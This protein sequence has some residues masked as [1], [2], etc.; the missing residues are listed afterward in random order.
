MYNGHVPINTTTS[1]R[2][3]AVKPGFKPTN[4]DTHTYIFLDDVI[5]QPAR[6]NGFPANWGHTGRGDYEMDPEVVNNARYRNTIK[7]DLLSVPT[8][9]LVMDVDDWFE[10]GG[11]GI[12][13]QGER[14]ERAVSAE[15][16]FPD[17]RQGFQINCSVMIVGGSS[18][19]RWKMDKLSMR[20]KFK[21]EYG[22]SKLRFPVFGGDVTDEFDTLVVDARMNNSWGYGGGVMLPNNSRP[23]ISGRPSQ[24][25][26]AQY[27]RD[28]FVA[29]IQN[30][31]GGYA[32]HGRHIHLYLNGLYWGLYWLHE[33]PDEHFAAVYFGGDDED[34]DVLKHRSSSVIS[35]T[36]ASYNRLFNIA[37]AGLASASQY[38]LIQQYLDVPNLIDYMITNFYV[39][40]TDWAHQN[41][42]ATYNKND[43]DGRWRY[44]SWDAEHVMEALNANVTGKNNDGGPTRLHQKLIGNTEYRM[45]FA[46]HV[47]RHFFNN[48]ILTP[49]GAKDLYQI[50]LD[51]VDRAVVAE[52]ARW[53]DNH[54]STPYT[55]GVDWIRERD[56]LFSEYFPRRS[57]IILNQIKS[58]GLYPNVE[59]P[60]FHV[61]SIYKHGGRIS[62]DDRFYITAPTGTIYLMQASNMQSKGLSL[63]APN[64]WRACDASNTELDLSAHFL[65]KK[66]GDQTS[67]LLA[68][69][70]MKTV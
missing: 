16:I 69:Y 37:N 23:W 45:L 11:Q 28:Q 67:P 58:R 62:S 33:R 14:S 25:D 34:Y 57:G 63:P 38:Q 8:L 12:Y 56:W 29:D 53:G 59:A 54:S 41:W 49:D 39:G 9:S 61:N 36:G 52:S 1:L 30:A 20:L 15:L 48:G 44:H 5:R 6:P 60:E 43:P 17:G 13:I 64:G 27:T 21:S 40:N 66:P 31:M 22:S 42:Y 55:R 32:P 19:N 10:S 47:H 50:R 4:I 3:I 7:D 46:D 70:I 51:D 68:Y 24:R 65:Y 26:V 2:A 18:P 35:G